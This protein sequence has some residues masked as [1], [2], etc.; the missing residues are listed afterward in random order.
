MEKSEVRNLKSEIGNIPTIILAG[1]LGTRLRSV[2][3]DLPKPM[4]PVNGKPF[5]HYI[6]QYL[7]KQGISH[8]ILSVGYKHESIKDFFGSSYLDIAIEYSVEEEPLGTGGGI[9]QAFDLVQQEA[10]V[11]NGDTFFDV[12]LR[13][14]KQFS[15]HTNADIAMSL[16]QMSNFDRYGIVVRDELD[17]AQ[18]FEEKRFTESGFING[19]AYLIQKKLFD[20]IEVVQKFSFEKDVLEKYVRSLNFFGKEFDGYFIDIGI[21]EDYNKAQIDFKS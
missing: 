8:V 16:K 7:S 11:L 10:F 1:G 6:F 5:L 3:Q 2:I 15:N 4:A 20:K 18:S 12:D 17:R 21:P 13:E 19:G 9:K 14:L